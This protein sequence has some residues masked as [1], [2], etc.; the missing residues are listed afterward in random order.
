MGQSNKPWFVS[1]F[2]TAAGV[3]VEWN[4]MDGYASSLASYS[5]KLP[6]YRLRGFAVSGSTLLATSTT[7]MKVRFGESSAAPLTSMA[8]TAEPGVGMLGVAGLMGIEGGY[9]AIQTTVAHANG[10]LT[11]LMWGD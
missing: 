2:S 1:G 4:P 3:I 6:N 8:L 5:G 9:I 7:P 11:V 10:G